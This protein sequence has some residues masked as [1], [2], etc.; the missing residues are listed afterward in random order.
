MFLSLCN[1]ETFEYNL[2][3]ETQANQML[4]CFPQVKFV[5]RFIIIVQ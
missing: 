5:L 2:C 4:L 1:L 3:F